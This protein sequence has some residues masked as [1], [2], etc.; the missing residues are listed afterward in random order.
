MEDIRHLRHPLLAV[1]APEF[2]FWRQL[3]WLVQ[4]AGH[5][6]SKMVFSTFSELQDPASASRTEFAMQEGAAAIVGF[7]NSGLGSRSR[8]V[9]KGFHRDLGC[10][11]K[12][13][14]EEF[15]TVLA[16]AQRGACIIL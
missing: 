14:A 8:G 6:V 12:R 9:G 10:Q 11:A 2:P 4:R 3:A 5:D 7:V 16:M 1:G 13:C 15:L